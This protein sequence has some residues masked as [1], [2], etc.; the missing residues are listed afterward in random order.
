V[1][2]VNWNELQVSCLQ[3]YK[4]PSALMTLEYKLVDANRVYLS[5]QKVRVGPAAVATCVII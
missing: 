4:Q 1:T 5:I 2:C 3:I